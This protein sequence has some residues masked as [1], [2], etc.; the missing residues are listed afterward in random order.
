[1]QYVI[2]VILL[3]VFVFCTLRAAKKGFFLTLFE[4]ASYIIAMVAGKIFSAALAPKVFDNF[5]R[6][7]VVSFVSDSMQKSG[8]ADFIGSVKNMVDS[9]PNSLGGFMQILGVQKEELVDK[10]AH[11]QNT[12][13]MAAE[14][15]DKVAAPLVTSV[16]QI[17]L[18][19][20]ISLVCIFLLRLVIRAVD[21]LL[22]KKLP[23]IKQV[24]STLGG[25]FGAI[26]G[27]LVVI[28]LAII[29]N[30]IISAT[31]NQ[32]AIDIANNSIIIKL[33]DGFMASLTGYKM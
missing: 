32:K 21:K 15:T 12:G 6:V 33:V 4:L 25:V 1:M 18:Y 26:K 7:R 24:N 3:A 23:A 10:V 27:L 11:L 29:V 13:D 16:L 20:L 5:F 19:I 9:I 2:D 14:I 31:G 30:V 28:L 17:L 22:I 8:A